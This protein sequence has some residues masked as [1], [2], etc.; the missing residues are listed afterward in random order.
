MSVSG[1]SSSS[2]SLAVLVASSRCFLRPSVIGSRM[3]GSRMALKM[4]LSPSMATKW[5]LALRQAWT[6]APVG[7]EE[8]SERKNKKKQSQGDNREFMK[9]IKC[10]C[11]CIAIKNYVADL[12][13]GLNEQ[14]EKKRVL[15]PTTSP[16]SAASH[17]LSVLCYKIEE[18]IIN[19]NVDSNRIKLSHR[20]NGE[21]R[22]WYLRIAPHQQ[23]NA[24]FECLQ[25]NNT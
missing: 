1:S 13:S 25:M 15:L 10:T 20:L 11:G 8:S 17:E 21:G 22:R 16:R 18:D 9:K 14:L 5:R 7:N 4:S 23:L 24:E 19:S 12:C 3:R 6:E 2:R